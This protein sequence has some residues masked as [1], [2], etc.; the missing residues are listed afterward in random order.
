MTIHMAFFL[1]FVIAELLISSSSCVLIRDS[2]DQL[3]TTLANNI[4]S[5]EPLEVLHLKRDVE[6]LFSVIKH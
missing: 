6:D 1:V 5:G 3:S 2:F 4:Y